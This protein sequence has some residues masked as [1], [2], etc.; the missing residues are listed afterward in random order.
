M[1]TRGQQVFGEG[2]FT[3]IIG[4][5]VVAVYFAVENV[6]SGRSAFHT[7]ELLG[8]PLV[9]GVP[10]EQAAAAAIFAYNG[11]HLLVFVVVGIVAAWI[12]TEMERHPALWYLGFFALFTGFAYDLVL[13]LMMVGPAAEPGWLSLLAANSLA[14]LGM[15]AYLWS[16]HPGLWEEIGRGGD[17]EER[18]PAPGDRS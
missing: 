9:A 17:P 1:R 5:A 13:L 15:G 12:V 14:A 3:G 4:Y 8:A 2:L 16:V 18:H 10:P 7:A 6:L 11:L